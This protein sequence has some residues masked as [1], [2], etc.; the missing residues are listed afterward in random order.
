MNNNIEFKIDINDD[1]INEDEK[2]NNHEI[3]INSSKNS[4]LN[5]KSQVLSNN[6]IIR[7]QMRNKT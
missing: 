6:N 5:S 7:H 2:P 4:K 3:N 1:N